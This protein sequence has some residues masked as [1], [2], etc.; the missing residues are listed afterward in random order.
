MP[1]GKT[2]RQILDTARLGNG[3]APEEALVLTDEKQTPLDGLVAAANAVPR[4]VFGNT[5][6]MCAIYPAKIGLCSGDC[7][8]CAQSSHHRCGVVPVNPAALDE[9]GIVANARE[10]HRAG[11]GH[12]GLV[13]SGESLSDAEFSHILGILARLRRETGMTVCASLGTL[14][15]GR[16]DELKNA[17]VSRYHHSLETARGYFPQICST[18]SY[19][20]KLETI[21]IARLA[22]MEI[23]CGGII[24][25]GETPAQRVEFAFAL[26]ALD[27]DCV[28]LNILR[29]IPGTRLEN[30]PPL[31]VDE[32]LR[33]I[34]V[35][36]LILPNKTLKFAGG[37]EDALGDEEYK[38]YAAGINAM[39]AGNYLTTPGKNLD[40]ELRRL[41]AAGYS[42]E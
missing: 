13:T 19:D 24:G 26:K 35:F 15:P 6:S 4:R 30:Q 17:G 20:G 1:E 8:F 28:P 42:A 23:C 33:T 11:V 3:I 14:T 7:A 18:H 41:E 38:G 34:A 16:A 25:M 29:P 5:V 22:G 32:I 40:E 27:A 36:R 10:L 21:A 2:A 31:P 37:R 39:L 9:D 12:Y